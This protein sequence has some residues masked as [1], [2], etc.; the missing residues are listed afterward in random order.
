[1][2]SG[3][4]AMLTLRDDGS[5]LASG[6]N[7]DADRYTLTAPIAG[8]TIAGLRLETIPDDR[9]PGG[10]AGRADETGDFVLSEIEAALQTKGAGEFA[11]VIKNGFADFSR[12]LQPIYQA[13]DSNSSTF[14]GVFPR[15]TQPHTAVFLFG[16]YPTQQGESQIL[17]IRLRFGNNYWA[18]HNLG[19]FRLS[20]TSDAEAL[21]GAP[22]RN[23][24]KDSEVADLNIA[25][26]KAHARQGHHNEAVASLT[27][28]LDLTSDRAGTARIVAD[29]L[30]EPDF[31]ALRGRAEFQKLEAEVEAR[32]KAKA[33]KQEAELK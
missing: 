16:P 10:G 26:A 6:Q 23:D 5:V 31:D 21:E 15:F 22:L 32:T 1:M 8:G 18:R 14:W 11:L 2:T 33:A 17:T 28:A 30:K 20:V 7:P 27:E 9:L 3:E 25:L 4:G 13:F 19:G 12:E 29:E 24:L